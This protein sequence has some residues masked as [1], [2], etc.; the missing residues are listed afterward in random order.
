MFSRSGWGISAFLTGSQVMTIIQKTSQA[1]DVTVPDPRKS[2]SS[3]C[4]R[5]CVGGSLAMWLLSAF[6]Q[7]RRYMAQGT[8]NRRRWLQL[9]VQ[10]CLKS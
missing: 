7:S 5:G 4:S 10:S 6:Q 9:P 2:D 3:V 8:Q 1:T